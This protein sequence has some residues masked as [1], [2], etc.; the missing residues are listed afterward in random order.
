[1]LHP[2][3]RLGRPGNTERTPARPVLDGPSSDLLPFLRPLFAQAPARHRV[4]EPHRGYDANHF[5]NLPPPSRTPPRLRGERGLHFLGQLF[6]RAV[7][8][9][10]VTP[11]RPVRPGTTYLLTRCCS[12][13]RF[14]LQPDQ[15]VCDV[16]TFVLALA[17]LRTGV[18]VHA[19]CVLG[20][21]YHA[22]VTDPR[23]NI[24]AF[25]HYVHEFVA[26][27]LNA[28]RGRWENM[29]SSAETNRV[30][31]ETLEAV[32]D[33]VGYTLCNPVSSG[34]VSQGKKWPGLRLWWADE[35][36][37]VK[38]P[39]VFFSAGGSIPETVR[40]ELV[41]P[42]QL[43]EAYADGGIAEIRAQLTTREDAIRTEMK[44]AGRKFLGV[45][46]IRR[47]KWWES[48]ESFAKRRGLRPRVATRNRWKRIE[49]L[50]RNR[51]FEEDHANARRA[52]LKGDRNV[53]FPFGTYAMR[54]LHKVR[55]AP[56]P[57][58]TPA[59]S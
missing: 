46:N 38:R 14:F 57:A 28:S 44:K 37:T 50:L 35:A 7:D 3:C 45:R 18:L 31:L 54:L 25:Y 4:S 22:V 24:P 47:Q 39:E 5:A 12:E 8:R 11:P 9:G 23:G 1:M 29:W 20:N 56:D 15:E 43:T 21:H 53:L 59:P 42:P 2:P 55:C 32:E 52:W 30:S 48:P 51:Q 13:R 10:G 49:A 58:L 34:L 26:K 41:P 16:F 27:C 36:V 40:L 6:W 33:K 17:A 19:V